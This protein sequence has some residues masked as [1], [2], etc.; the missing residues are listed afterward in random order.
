[1]GGGSPDAANAANILL[2][3]SDRVITGLSVG[4]HKFQC[5]IH[6]WMQLTVEVRNKH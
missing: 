5:L 2:P 6:P 1:V 4:Q 3:G